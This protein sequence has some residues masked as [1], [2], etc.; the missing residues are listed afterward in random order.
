MKPLRTAVFTMVYN[1]SLFLPVWLEHYGRLFGL[2]NCFV[3]DDGSDDSSISDARIRNLISKQRGELD[4]DERALL[5]SCIHSELLTRYDQVIYTDAD[6]LIVVD[7]A[8]SSDLGAYLSAHNHV[9][10]T[11]IGFD[12]IHRTSSE[13]PLNLSGPLFEQ[14]NYLRFRKDYCK[15]LISRTPLK[16][17]AGF[18]A[19]DLKPVYDKNLFLF[20]LR[21][22]D[23]EYSRQRIRTLN[24][25][26]FSENSRRKAHGTHFQWSEDAYLEHLYGLPDSVFSQASRKEPI[27]FFDENALCDAS[28]LVE[29]P[30]RFKNTVQLTSLSPS[31]EE[32]TAPENAALLE[33]AIQKAIAAI[34]DR[35]RND[36]CPCGSG[37]RLKQ[38]HGAL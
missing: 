27:D 8:I 19:S 35:R 4:E 25:I 6:E 5:V 26:R 29:I 7:P 21:A 31:T 2:E 18:H 28:E 13:S 16:W 1:E 17:V 3:I 15:T 11:P 38:C 23:Q 20:H 10:L 36:P 24:Q 33:R 9:H 14:R 30:L 37:K 12:V 34:P 32:R 22:V